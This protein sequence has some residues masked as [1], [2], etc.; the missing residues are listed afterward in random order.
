[1][2]A[3]LSQHAVAQTRHRSMPDRADRA[4]RDSEILRDLRRFAFRVEREQH[5]EPVPLRERPQARRHARRVESGDRWRRG[6]DRHVQE[7]RGQRFPP[8][9]DPAFGAEPSSGW[10]PG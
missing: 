4:R 7:S 6:L 10:S 8:P 1:M 9:R 5:D 2:D 3:R